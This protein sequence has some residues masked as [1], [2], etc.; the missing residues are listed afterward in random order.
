M[1]N[2]SKTS[3][4]SKSKSQPKSKRKVV[5][6]KVPTLPSGYRVV[7]RTPSWEIEKNPVIAGE[8]GP[9]NE[10]EFAQPLKK[11]QKKAEVRTVRTVV[12]NDETIGPVTVWE[13]GMLRDFFDQTSEGD[14]VRIEFLGYGNAKPG[15]NAP[16]LFSCGVKD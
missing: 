4:K 3:A 13:S 7:G 11:G 6:N 15:Q 8:R 10:V 12:V 14:N 9:T 1:A 5:A 2:K 16:K